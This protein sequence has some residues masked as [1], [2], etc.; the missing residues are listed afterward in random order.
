MEILIPQNLLNELGVPQIIDIRDKLPTNPNYTWEQLTG[1]RDVNKITTIALHHDA[2]SK[3]KTAGIT[4]V[5]LAI[6]IARSHIRLTS[7][8]KKGDP[9]FPYD[10]WI[11]NGTAYLCNDLLPLK[12]GVGGCNGYT[13]HICVSGE[14]SSADTLADADKRMLIAVVLAYKQGLPAYKETKAHKDFPNAKTACPGYDVQSLFAEIG[15]VELQ[16]K[17]ATDP[18]V[19]KLKM[20]RAKNQH[21]YLYEEYVKNPEGMKWLEPYLL[22]MDEVTREMGMYFGKF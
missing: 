21:N 17:A 20:Q 16:L 14:Y 7:N 6:N 12:Y 2:L 22:R 11:R 1:N 3:S 9:G 13:V 18:E 4:D 5:Q 8:E 15:K 10:V 19:A